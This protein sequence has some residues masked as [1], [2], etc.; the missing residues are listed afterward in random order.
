MLFGIVVLSVP[1]VRRHVYETFYYSHFLLGVAYIG[2]M[3]WHAGLLG[4]SW[5]YLWVSIAIWLL[6]I[7]VRTFW[8]QR[9]I[10][11]RQ[12]NWLQGFIAQISLLPGDVTKIEVLLPEDM[13]T[14]SAQ[15]FYLRFPEV[16]ALDSH[17]FTM[18]WKAIEERES[19]AKTPAVSTLSFFIRSRDGFTKRLR[20][21]TKQKAFNT[22]RVWLDGP[23]GGI[24]AKLDNLYDHIVFVAG[25]IGITACLPWMQHIISQ[26]ASGNKAIR[27]SSIKLVWA[28]RHASHIEWVDKYLQLLSQSAT[29]E[30]FLTVE[31]HCTSENTRKAAGNDAALIVSPASDLEKGDSM[32]DGSDVQRRVGPPTSQSQLVPGRPRMDSVLE[33]LEAGSTAVIGESVVPHGS[34]V[35]R[36]EEKR[37]TAANPSRLRTDEPEGRSIECMR[38]GSN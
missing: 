4:D 1:W 10:N 6:S 21:T 26:K 3:F 13:R 8:Y 34:K 35:E 17:P 11:I 28:V 19:A 31:I 2:L 25:G 27:L 5:T 24:S 33:A 14:R 23:Y 7:V 12:S 18:A 20:S 38:Q 9:A 30:G 16:S 36:E 37:L 15:H 22:T 29:P 32:S